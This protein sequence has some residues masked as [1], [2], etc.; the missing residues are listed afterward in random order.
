MQSVHLKDGSVVY[1]RPYRS[2]TIDDTTAGLDT[3]V[4]QV[5][6]KKEVKVEP[7]K[8]TKKGN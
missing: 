1:A 6:G 8:T 4:W 5:E 2:V 7:V 3:K